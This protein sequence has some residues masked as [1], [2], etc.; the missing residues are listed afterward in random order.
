M[1]FRWLGFLISGLALI[2]S[3]STVNAECN[4]NRISCSQ[5]EGSGS[6]ITFNSLDYA[7]NKYFWNTDTC[8]SDSDLGTLETTDNG[9]C[10]LWRGQSVNG[11]LPNTF[12]DEDCISFGQAPYGNYGCPCLEPTCVL[13]Y[14]GDDNRM[15]EPYFA[16]ARKCLNNSCA[17]RDP[18]GYFPETPNYEPV[19][20]Y[21][22]SLSGTAA[23]GDKVRVQVYSHD[24]AIEQFPGDPN[25]NNYMAHDTDIKLSWNNTNHTAQGI[26]SSTDATPVTTTSPA[27]TLPALPSG[28]QYEVVGVWHH[29]NS[30]TTAA[31]SPNYVAEYFTPVDNELS[32]NGTTATFDLGDHAS[33]FGNVHRTYFDLQVVQIV[34]E[35]TISKTTDPGTSVPRHPGDTIGYHITITNTGDVALSNFIATDVLD[36]NLSFLSGNAGVSHSGQTVTLNFGNI[37]QGATETLSFTVTVNDDTPTPSQICNTATA[38]HLGV[39]HT[40]NN[41]CYNIIPNEDVSFAL[42][43]SATPAEGTPRQPGDTITYTIT[44]HNTGNTTLPSVEVTDMFDDY[45][46]LVSSDPG[47]VN[48]GSGIILLFDDMTPGETKSKSFI[49]S[50]DND[51]P[52]PSEVCNSATATNS[53]VTQTTNTVCHPVDPIIIT[54]FSL[55]KSANPVSGSHVEVGNTITYTVSTTN[56][57]NTTLSNVIG[58]DT[59]DSHLTFVT[60]DAGVSHVNG[61]VTIQFAN[62]APGA[63]V[64]KNFQVVVDSMPTPP[65]ISNAFS[66]TVNGITKTSN[67]TTHYIDTAN[68]PDFTLTKTANPDT[69]TVIHP[70]ETITYSITATNTGNVV[71]PSFT[72]TDTLNSN[73]T[74]VSGDTGVS[75]VGQSVTLDFGNIAVGASVTK[76]FIVS[77]NAN[78]PTPSQVCNQATASNSGVSHSSL[79][80]CH[81]VT[82]NPVSNFFITKSAVPGNNSTVTPGDII[83]YGLHGFNTGNVLLTNL[84][85]TDVLN[86]NVEYTGSTSSNVTYDANTHTV[87]ATFAA[88]PISTQVSASFTVKIKDTAS[89]GIGFCNEATATANDLTETS[90]SVCHY[91]VNEEVSLTKTADIPAGTSVDPGQILTY[92][93]SATNNTVDALDIVV[94]DPLDPLLQ[95]IGSSDPNVTYD[96]G[97]HTISIQ[98]DNVDSFST[99]SASFQAQVLDPGAPNTEVCNE[100]SLVSATPSGNGG[101]GTSGGGN[102]S[103]MYKVKTLFQNLLANSIGDQGEPTAWNPQRICHPITVGTTTSF[104]L[105][106]TSVPAPNTT[107][108]PGDTI[109]YSITTMNTG[110]LPLNNLEVTDALSPFV[111]FPIQSANVVYDP[112]THSIT[113]NA[114]ILNPGDSITFIFQVTVN[115][116][117]PAGST[118]CNEAIGTANNLTITSNSVCHSIISEEVSLTKTADI[119]AGTP[120]DPGQILTY[121]ISATN[122]TTAPLNILVTDPL[123]SLLQFIGSSDPNL[124]YDAGTHTVSIAFNNV[125]ALD[126]VYTSFQAQVLDPGAPNTEVCN[127]VSLVSANS[128]SESSGGLWNTITNTIKNLFSPVKNLF[129][130]LTSSVFDIRT[131]ELLT[132]NSLNDNQGGGISAF[133]P[134]R[135]CHPITQ[136]SGGALQLEKTSNPA[137]GSTVTTGDTITYTVQILNTSPTV[138]GTVIEDVIPDG[139][140]F[141]AAGTASSSDPNAVTDFEFNTALNTFFMNVDNLGIQENATFTFDVTVTEPMTLQDICNQAEVPNFEG[142]QYLSNSVCVTPFSGGDALLL[143]KTSNPIAGSTVLTGDTVLYKVR[144]TNNSGAELTNTILDTLD[145]GLSFL[146]PGSISSSDIGATG[147]ISF[148]NTSSV[149]SLTVNNLGDGEWMTLEFSAEIIAPDNSQVCNQANITDLAGQM[150]E[151]EHICLT[152]DN[153]GTG[154]NTFLEKSVSPTGTIAN[155]DTLTYTIRM[156]SDETDA[157]STLINDTLDSHLIYLGNEMV[158]TA[159]TSITGSITHDGSATGGLVELTVNDLANGWI[160]FSFDVLVEGA[161]T[162]TQICN[163]ATEKDGNWF[164]NIVCSSTEGGGGGGGGGET[165]ST[166]G[167]C[168]DFV[169]GSVTCRKH[170]PHPSFGEEDYQTWK[171]CA[172]NATKEE[173]VI[174]THDWAAAVGLLAIG[175]CTPDDESSSQTWWQWDG[176]QNL[177]TWPGDHNNQCNTYLEPCTPCDEIEAT[178]TKTTS[179]PAVAKEENAHY[180]TILSLK[181]TEP[182]GAKIK[183]TGMKIYDLTIPAESGWIYNHEMAGN[184]EWPWNGIPKDDPASNYFEFSGGIFYLEDDKTFVIDYEM[185]T[186]LTIK[187]DTAQ[188]RN[189]AFAV[190]EYQIE[191]AEGWSDPE[192][193]YVGNQNI[194]ECQNLTILDIIDASTSTGGASATVKIVRPFVEVRGGGNVGVQKLD[195]TT[196]NPFGGLQTGGEFEDTL[197]TG[198]IL[199]GEETNDITTTENLWDTY[200]GQTSD[201]KELLGTTWQTTPDDADVYFTDGDVT[202]TIENAQGLMGTSKTF[203]INGTLTI[204]ENFEPTAFA[205]FIADQIIID[206]DVEKMIGVF[207]ADPGKIS[208]PEISYKQLVVSGSLMGDATDLLAKRKFIGESPETLLKPSIKIDYDLRLLDDTPPALELFLSEDWTQSTEE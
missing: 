142:N 115:D 87:T 129:Q 190:I 19:P 39:S 126:T 137:P 36:T 74:F 21:E 45:I 64:S 183:I 122:N 124:T 177:Y 161:G 156:T 192:I 197:S 56:T 63:M 81:D 25:Y 110:D 114:T 35:F 72:A 82:Q 103:A 208:S 136:P 163:Q 207:I 169:S 119:P 113:G 46:S 11:S 130:S 88:V 202:L 201:T 189:V 53:G 91:I 22:H 180:T 38:T 89:T 8:V 178:I 97:T 5:P 58:T 76:S 28:M 195:D 152:V 55:A 205:A 16:S 60:G 93:I 154:G 57:G 85:I 32:I 54:D 117:A 70:G 71:L 118:F 182:S 148:D 92:T 77:I 31:E 125:A 102:S 107:L 132:A 106:K 140:A 95:Y 144:I 123:D 83:S 101:T 78:T 7:Q 34:P 133:I 203:V 162:S 166:I 73:L 109:T 173:L 165:I 170:T 2:L 79:D 155:G 105:T 44:A 13:D 26:V 10:I 146:A 184:S 33:S 120:V 68:N 27:I 15:K 200:E 84:V 30:A 171:D 61:I 66:A 145:A 168:T 138:L 199:T 167:I 158:T 194:D 174:C 41:V 59:L 6:T 164:S 20:T 204:A 175:E 3:F 121:T 62:I 172:K 206:K 43:K 1:K 181:K 179:T 49:V 37:E 159:N 75:H 150:Y 139:T 12:T 196:E 188:V 128:S 86:P 29:Y 9:D 116:N 14:V 111:S 52:T 157:F 80:V 98:F 131:L 18:L 94:T 50:I 42:A 191:Q 17:S 23:L 47:Y 135:I 104:S 160:E 4:W 112:T 185:D 176:Y 48:I 127:E 187:A 100:V 193:F 198:E 134:E 65:W 24:N 108:T 99:V 143:E 151:S 96:S 51:I 149:L 90:N 147:N 69:T 40:S 153:G 186:A 141:L 67:Q